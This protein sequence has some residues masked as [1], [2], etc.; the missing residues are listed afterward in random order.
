MNRFN[1]LLSKTFREN[2]T[3]YPNS[4]VKLMKVLFGSDITIDNKDTLFTLMPKQ[5]VDKKLE[6]I[7]QIINS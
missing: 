4:Y 5:D 2:Y 1:A 7:R 3:K 6:M